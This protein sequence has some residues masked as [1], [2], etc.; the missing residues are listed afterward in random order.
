MVRSSRSAL[1]AVVISTA[2]ADVDGSPSTLL[3]TF[4][5]RY[6]QPLID[7]DLYVPNRWHTR[8]P[9]KT[10]YYAYARKTGRRIHL[11]EMG[12]SEKASLQRY[13]GWAR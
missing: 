3:L 7:E 9:T 1:R 2:D 13:K 11:K 6:M 10:R 8:L 5:F 12:A 4:F